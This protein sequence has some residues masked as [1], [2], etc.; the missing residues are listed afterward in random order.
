MSNP[1]HDDQVTSACPN[2]C[3]KSLWKPKTPPV[4]QA[5]QPHG[6]RVGRDQPT[7]GGRDPVSGGEAHQCSLDTGA[8]PHTMDHPSCHHR[9]QHITYNEYLPMVL[10]RENLHK[11]GRRGGHYLT[12]SSSQAWC[13]MQMDTSMVMTL[14]STPQQVGRPRIAEVSPCPSPGLHHGGVQVR[15]LPATLHHREVVLQPPVPGH[16]A[17]LRDAAAALRS[18]QGWLGR[19]LRPGDGQPGAWSASITW[20]CQGGAGNG[21]QRHFRG[22]QP[23]V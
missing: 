13:S 15:P 10:G 12:G 21:R 3:R 1:Y 19:P 9:P 18:L 20:S 16:P 17:A 5:A 14:R 6:E 23:L 7:L 2:S 22:H 11:H 8:I 4:L